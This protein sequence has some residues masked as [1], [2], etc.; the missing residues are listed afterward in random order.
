MALFW[1]PLV[2][3]VAVVVGSSVFATLRGLELFRTFRR[4]SGEAGAGLERV[5]DSSAGI[6]RHLS[7]AAASG[8]RLDASLR[9]LRASRQRLNV[10]TSALAD[11]RASLDRVTAIVPRK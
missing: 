1:L 8:E 11:V 7:L 2:F 9:R 6:E 4:L 5:S 3:A 10:L